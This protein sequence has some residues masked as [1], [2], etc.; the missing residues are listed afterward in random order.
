VTKL[1]Q[2]YFFYLG[3]KMEDERG[4][5]GGRRE[6]GGN[7]CHL[8][9]PG[10]M[11]ADRRGEGEARQAKRNDIIPSSVEKKKVPSLLSRHVRKKK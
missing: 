11:V 1:L 4:K 6:S 8:P 9:T 7:A 3:W 10:E 5:G 2:D